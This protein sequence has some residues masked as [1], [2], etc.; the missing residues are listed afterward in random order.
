MKSNEAFQQEA[1][2]TIG[3]RETL[4][5]IL[6]PLRTRL[7]TAMSK[8]AKT[9]KELSS[10]VGVEPTKLYYHVKLLQK[11]GIIA[12]VEERQVGNLTETSYLCTA[13]DFFVDPELSKDL[14]EGSTFEGTIATFISALR[15]SLLGSYRRM[16]E[17]KQA[18]E[19]RAEEEGRKPESQTFSLGI[20][21]LRLDEAEAKDFLRRFNE[22]VA[23]FDG[24]RGGTS[25][26][27][28]QY[29]IGFAFYPSVSPEDE[30]QDKEKK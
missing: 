27:G 18:R 28:R 22:L 10:I 20:Q 2:K 5:V 25:E 11:A 17:K 14:G 26:A 16:R 13:E 29:E 24:K 8:E 21:A 9:V 19:G 3:D 4:K 1:S 12:A 6:H 30:P 15:S 23:E 7:I